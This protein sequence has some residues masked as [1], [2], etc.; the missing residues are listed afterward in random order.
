MASAVER[1]KAQNK[2][3]KQGEVRIGAKGK[4]VRRYNAKTGK[5]DVTKKNV[6]PG[7]AMRPSSGAA[8]ATGVPAGLRNPQPS[9]PRV[10]D[11]IEVYDEKTNKYVKKSRLR[12]GG[13]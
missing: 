13:R 11:Y 5:W 8:K 10:S 12:Y 7:V 2:G 1:R 3:V 6:S 9:K 4:T